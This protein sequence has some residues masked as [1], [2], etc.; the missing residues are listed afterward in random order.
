MAHGL[1]ISLI[2]TIPEPA[3]AAALFGLA[4]V[5]LSALRKRR[6]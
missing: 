5:I 2:G 4:A 3:Q 6:R 1:N